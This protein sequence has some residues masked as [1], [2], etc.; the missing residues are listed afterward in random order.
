MSHKLEN[1]RSFTLKGQQSIFS[2]K[3]QSFKKNQTFNTMIEIDNSDV[4]SCKTWVGT[5]C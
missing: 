1:K 3:N 2:I 5:G 4:H